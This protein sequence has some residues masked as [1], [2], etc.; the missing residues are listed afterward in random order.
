MFTNKLV[1]NG[2]LEIISSSFSNSAIYWKLPGFSTQVVVFRKQAKEILCFLC[3]F[4][5]KET[6]TSEEITLMKEKVGS[7]NTVFA[8]LQKI[9]FFLFMQALFLVS[10]DVSI[11]DLM[12]VAAPCAILCYLEAI[13]LAILTVEGGRK[14]LLHFYSVICYMQHDVLSRLNLPF[15][16]LANQAGE[17]FLFV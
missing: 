9:L 2:S 15:L 6:W 4:T 13:F 14:F 10:G 7:R 3:K 5:E 12:L 16:S 11:Y 8:L 17:Y 1:A